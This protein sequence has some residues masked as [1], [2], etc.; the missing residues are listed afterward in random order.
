MRRNG[1][2]LGSAI[3]CGTQETWDLRVS[4]D[5][6]YDPS[7]HGLDGSRKPV[8]VGAQF[9]SHCFELDFNPLNLLTKEIAKSSGG[10]DSATLHDGNAF[11]EHFDVAQD[12]ARED[13]RF[14]F[15][16]LFCEE[17]SDLLS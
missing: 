3:E 5:Y 9:G 10:R 8:G 4:L 14:P 1:K 7:M 16:L 2:D 17:C 15:L 12:M 13:Q 11:A 6:G